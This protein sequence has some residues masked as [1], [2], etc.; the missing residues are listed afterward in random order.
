MVYFQSLT[1]LFDTLGSDYKQ[2]KEVMV[3]SS[4]RKKWYHCNSLIVSHKASKS[5]Q[6]ICHKTIHSPKDTQQKRI[7]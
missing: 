2:D 5:D 6:N 4:K 7:S 3:G 1:L